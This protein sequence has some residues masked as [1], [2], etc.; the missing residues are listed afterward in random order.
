M[1]KLHEFVAHASAVR[2]LAFAPR[3]PAM[4]A[5]GGDD[6]RVNV[7]RTGE[8]GAAVSNVWTLSSNKSGIESLCFDAD[9]QCVIS[10]AASGAIRVFDLQEGKL[11]RS[12]NGHH[13][14][15][16]SLHYHPYGE[17]LVSG[18]GD[19]TMKVWDVRNRRCIQTYSG[20]SKE[21]TC[22][23]FSPDGRWVASSSRD[24]LLLLWDLV[25]GKLLQSLQIPHSHVTSFEFC[26]VEFIVGA[27]LA[28]K[29]LRLWDLESFESIGTTPAEVGVIR[30]MRF[31]PRS[32][33]ICS[34]SESSL[35]TWTWDPLRPR[36][37]PRSIPLFSHVAGLAWRS[38][39]TE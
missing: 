2:C 24:G 14:N 15:T 25:A 36:W 34:A 30:A 23:R 32:K 35:R 9:E 18:S 12:L 13:V 6:C 27:V 4:V 17:F 21:V 8:A 1:E 20:H 38:A 5:S 3:S 37:P 33:R 22:A 28:N 11:V 16:C 10:G 19:T 26:P 29:T 39:G 31:S 7:W